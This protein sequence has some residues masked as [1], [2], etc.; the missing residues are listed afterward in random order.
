MH[1][2]DHDAGH[3]HDDATWSLE[4]NL[5]WRLVRLYERELL[6]GILVCHIL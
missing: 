5:R 3:V 4:A 1:E 6:R 2:A